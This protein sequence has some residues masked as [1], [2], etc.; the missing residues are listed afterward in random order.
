MRHQYKAR[1]EAVFNVNVFTQDFFTENATLN[2]TVPRLTRN[3]LSHTT[4]IMQAIFKHVSIRRT[5]LDTSSTFLHTYATEY[6]PIYH[7]A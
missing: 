4:L 1:Q 2:R 3:L 5:N 7:C 6:A